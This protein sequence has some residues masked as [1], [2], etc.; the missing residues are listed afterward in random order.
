MSGVSTS[1]RL[2]SW[3]S[4]LRDFGRGIRRSIGV[5]VLVRAPCND[6]FIVSTCIACGCI[7]VDEK[8]HVTKL[9]TI[10]TLSNLQMSQYLQLIRDLMVTP[11]TVK[12]AEVRFVAVILGSPTITDP[13]NQFTPYYNLAWEKLGSYN[14]PEREHANLLLPHVLG[15]GRRR[16]RHVHQVVSYGARFIP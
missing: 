8:P 1:P 13:W 2:V 15:Y 16:N 4:W 9:Y 3:R 12:E 5:L 14:R 11:D 7:Q 6:G 10:W